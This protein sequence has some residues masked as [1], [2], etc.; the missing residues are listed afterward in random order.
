MKYVLY[1]FHNAVRHPENSNP[2][3]YGI[4]KFP[5]KGQVVGVE[6]GSSIGEV[7]D[8]LIHDVNDELSEA[9]PKCQVMTYAP[10]DE[11]YGLEVL[12]NESFDYEMQGIVVDKSK[13]VNTI[14]YFGVKEMDEYFLSPERTSHCETEAHNVG[15]N[16]FLRNIHNNRNLL[17][18]S[19]IS[20]MR[21]D[22]LCHLQNLIS[23]TTGAMPML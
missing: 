11:M 5:V 22:H 23:K 17:F 6:F 4:F 1:R 8:E 16:M 21:G 20:L 9:Y 12:T 19:I 14:I 18:K 7:T 3:L 13:P 10:S 15:D 2:E